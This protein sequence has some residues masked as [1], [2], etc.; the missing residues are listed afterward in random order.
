MCHMVIGSAIQHCALPS[1]CV[2]GRGLWT[3]VTIAVS[4]R[5]HHW[6]SKLVST[7]HVRFKPVDREVVECHESNLIHGWRERAALHNLQ[8]LSCEYSEHG[9]ET[10]C[11]GSHVSLD[12]R[13]GRNVTALLPA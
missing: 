13:R 9:E 10:T 5:T 2:V 7:N 11:R 3:E 12:L 1:P 8:R 4:R 6:R